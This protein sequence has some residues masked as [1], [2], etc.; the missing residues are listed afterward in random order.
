MIKEIIIPNWMFYLDNVFAVN[1][2][3]R[4]YGI[5][6]II[7]TNDKKIIE[8]WKKNKETVLIGIGKVCDINMNNYDYNQNIDII[9]NIKLMKIRSIILDNIEDFLI[10]NKIF[11]YQDNIKTKLQK[12]LYINKDND[13]KKNIKDYTNNYLETDIYYILEHINVNFQKYDKYNNFEKILQNPRSFFL[14]F[15]YKII[16]YKKYSSAWLI[17]KYFWKK[18][19]DKIWYKDN[20]E[21]LFNKIDEELVTNI[22]NNIWLSDIIEKYNTLYSITK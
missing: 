14:P 1:I 4:I 11:L 12:I 13:I 19:L 2:L 20:I 15:F 8:E 6:P 17:W 18:Y 9:E 22:E 16:W 5:I 3:K 21:E 7:R 10:E